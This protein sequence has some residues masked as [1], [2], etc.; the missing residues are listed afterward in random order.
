MIATTGFERLERTRRDTRLTAANRTEKSRTRRTGP[1]SL[2][3]YRDGLG[4]NG[5]LV[6]LDDHLWRVGRVRTL[7]ELGAGVRQPGGKMSR[8]SS[9]ARQLRD[10]SLHQ[11]SHPLWRGVLA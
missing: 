11:E 2:A 8:Y 5:V 7:Q 3:I 1:V 10:L 9:G 4:P 6:L